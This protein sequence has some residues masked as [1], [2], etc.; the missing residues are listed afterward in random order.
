LPIGPVIERLREATRS[1][2][3]EFWADDIS[4]LEPR[5]ADAHRIHGSRQVTDLYLL[6]L[7]VHRGGRFATFDGTVPI[8]AI[9]GAEKRHLVVL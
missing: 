2:H 1:P 7:A 3:H 6:A 4:A 5:I 8:S 9:R